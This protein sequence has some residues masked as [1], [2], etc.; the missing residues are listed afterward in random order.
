MH[1]QSF[2]RR[3]KPTNDGVTRRTFLG[4]TLGGGVALLAGG[5]AGFFGA[6]SSMA[7]TNP[8]TNSVFKLGGDLQV[9]RLGFGAMRLPA[10]ASGVGRPI[11]KA[12]AKF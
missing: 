1:D 3:H 5:S 6:A 2:G 7:V 8:D 10:T 11:A 12:R 9:N 4:T